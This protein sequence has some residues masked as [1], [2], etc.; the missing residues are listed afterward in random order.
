MLIDFTFLKKEKIVFPDFKIITRYKN[1]YKGINLIKRNI[2]ICFPKIN[3]PNGINIFSQLNPIETQHSRILAE[4]LSP[5]GKHNMG[6]KF[7]E[8]FFNNVIK[9][10]PFNNNETWIVT[11]E[12]ERYDIWIRNL[13]Y[14][15]III[16]ENKS[17]KAGDQPN[18]LY[19][20]WYHGIHKIQNNIK[21]NKS[22]YG[23]ILYISPDYNKKP[24]EQTVLPPEELSKEK[25]LIPD[26]AI[27]TIYFH[28]EI[29]EWLEKCLNEDEVKKAPEIYFYI[30]QYKDFWRY[31]YVV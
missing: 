30:K 26:N 22:K 7:L 2:N 15:T 8:L 25:I 10:I 29:D 31:Y 13:D 21:S 5:N 3:K 18:Q 9:D 12:K 20:Y 27:R 17:N 4:L 23:R 16:L 6:D 19:R 14:S 28:D 1:M 11:A 24:D